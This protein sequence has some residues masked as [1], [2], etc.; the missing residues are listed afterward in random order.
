MQLSFSLDVP[1]QDAKK[2]E[3]PA[4]SLTG[5]AATSTAIGSALGTVA[6][7][8]GGTVMSDDTVTTVQSANSTAESVAAYYAPLGQALELVD[9]VLNAVEA[10]SQVSLFHELVSMC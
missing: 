10:F 9:R 6:N 2:T 8:S 4:R 3:Q 5:S 7:L 1:S